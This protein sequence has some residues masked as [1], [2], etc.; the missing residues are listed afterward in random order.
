MTC[1]ITNCDRPVA[2]AHVCAACA[3]RTPAGLRDAAAF[4]VRE[5][6]QSEVDE[7]REL[8]K[9]ALSLLREM[10]VGLDELDER[11]SDEN[12]PEWAGGEA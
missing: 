3:N 4:A 9:L 10:P 7:A 12:L 2:D 1:A 11:L 5:K 6:M 8:A